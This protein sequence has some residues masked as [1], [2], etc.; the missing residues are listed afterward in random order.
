MNLN[1][2]NKSKFDESLEAPYYKLQRGKKL[3]K[4]LVVFSSMKIPAGRFTFVRSLEKFPYDVLYVNDINNGW[5]QTGI[6]GLGTSVDEACT[7]IKEIAKQI[8][9]KD[10]FTLGSSMGGY[11]ALLFGAKLN[12]PSL[13]FDPETVLDLPDSRSAKNMPRTAT[14]HYNDLLPLLESSGT[15][16]HIY[17]GEMDIV[18]LISAQRMTV[19]P[20]VSVS[21]IADQAHSTAAHLH[22]V[23]GLSQVSMTFVNSK[24]M[25][26]LPNPGDLCNY[27]A[28][29]Q[30]LVASDEAIRQRDY[31]NAV[32]ILSPITF[33]SARAGV[34]W[35]R[36]GVAQLY[37]GDLHGAVNSQRAAVGKCP[38][39]GKAHLQ[40]GISLRRTKF[41]TEAIQAFDRASELQPNMA[42]AHYQRGL[43]FRDMQLYD[44]AENAFSSAWKL[45]PN[46]KAIVDAL[47]AAIE[48]CIQSRKERLLNLRRTMESV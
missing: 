12:A 46:N 18:D 28:V 3:G 25:P 45:E 34:A 13:A 44:D 38:S 5:Y 29:V 33:K 19:L 21:T 1:M 36:L 6:P 11:G 40:L 43:T 37:A 9:A 16:A 26:E 31:K 41:H 39:F 48:T 20:R 7:S 22:E 27:P 17:A 32:S 4:L 47:A 8:R 2:L 35:Y 15:R 30:A 42:A 24:P 23:Y 14:R 10:I